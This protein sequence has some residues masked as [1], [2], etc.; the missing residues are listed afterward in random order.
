MTDSKSR[1]APYK[2]TEQGQ[3]QAQAIG[4][5]FQ[6]LLVALE[7][8]CPQGREMSLATTK[9]DEACIWA[10]KAMAEDAGN[11]E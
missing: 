3:R 1:F 8:M 4:D 10:K 9:L 11:Q 7:A 2:L 6:D 5:V